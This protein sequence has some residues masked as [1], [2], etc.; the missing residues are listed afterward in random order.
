MTKEQEN[1][2]YRPYD[3]LRAIGFTKEEAKGFLTNVET[4]LATQLPPPPQQRAPELSVKFSNQ[5]SAV[6]RSRLKN[7]FLIVWA[8][9]FALWLYAIGLQTFYPQSKNWPLATWLPIRMDY[10][11]EAAFV[12]SFAVAA[13]ITMWNTKRGLR[14]LTKSTGLKA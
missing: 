11:G 14:N 1:P 13:L 6:R 2:D 12:F 3:T 7:L 8:Y 5:R 10:V 4:A 9:A